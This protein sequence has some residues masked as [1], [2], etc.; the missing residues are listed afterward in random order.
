M[1][2]TLNA[3]IYVRVSTE[4]QRD[5]GYSIDG[6]IRELTDYCDK[7]DYN[8][9]DVYNDAGHSAKDMKR[10]NLERLIKDIEKGKID[11]VVAIKVDRLTREGYDG[12]WFLRFCKEHE[13]GLVFLYENY[14]VTTPNGEMMYGMSLLFGQRERREIGARTKRGMEEAVKQ[15][16]YPAKVPYGYMRNLDG[17]LEIEPISAKVVQDIFELYSKGTSAL[18]IAEIMAKENRYLTDNGK[19]QEQRIT[20]IISNFIYKG[21]LHWGQYSRKEQNILI[22]PNHSPA[23]ISQELF[24]RCQIQKEKNGHGNYGKKIHIFH[25][26]VRCPICHKI[27]NNCY[28]VKHRNKKIIYNYY[29]RCDN[30]HCFNKGKCYNATKIEQQLIRLLNELSIIA[31]TSEYFINLPHMKEKEE[32]DKLQ[33]AIDKLILSEKKLV[34][35][36]LQ[37]DITP[38]YINQKL[39]S[40]KTERIKLERTKEKLLNGQYYSYNHNL[41]DLFNEN[42]RDNII[43]VKKIWELLNEQTRREIIDQY[44]QYIDVDIDKNYNISITHI[45]FRSEF[46]QNKLFSLSQYLTEKVE[47][48]EKEIIYEGTCTEEQLTKYKEKKNVHSFS[49]LMKNISFKEKNLEKA[50][51]K[52]QR[53]AIEFVYVIDGNHAI[54]DVM[55]MY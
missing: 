39:N 44:I 51:M 7:Q 3:A 38:E 45:E 8:I 46:L 20:N 23:I 53:D 52:L 12:Q 10:P 21:E 15:G 22:V 30:K 47:R 33:S 27:M 32:I 50:I 4:E 6:Q 19:W 35:A 5:Y 36:L 24:D 14:D 42:Q 17:K 43:G 1:N 55:L 40:I 11:V 49:E 18:K 48:I 41:K 31:I 26:V 28:T 34:N 16:K 37:T 13:C 29:V 25:Q 9:I 54:Q 2:R